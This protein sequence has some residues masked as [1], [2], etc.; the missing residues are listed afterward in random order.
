MSW[1]SFMP[2]VTYKAFMLSI[3]T[4]LQSSITFT[5]KARASPSGAAFRLAPTGQAPGLMWGLY[6]KTLRIR[7]LQK[8]DRFRSKLV[9][10]LLLVFFNNLYKIH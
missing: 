7:N 5:S 3:V 9:P 1:V 4:P 2:S 8:L 10:L 6:Y